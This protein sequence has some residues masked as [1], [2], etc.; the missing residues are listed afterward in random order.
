MAYSFCKKMKRHY[1]L[2]LILWASGFWFSLKAADELDPNNYR[3]IH[4]SYFDGKKYASGVSHEVF[5]KMTKWNFESK[6]AP[7]VSPQMAYKLAKERLDKI[8]MRKGLGW[9]LE[10]VGLT[11]VGSQEEGKWIWKVSFELV[12]TDGENMM[13][14]PVRMAFFV[15]MDGDLIE[16]VVSEHKR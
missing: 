2:F 10:Q 6:K 11:P 5:E 9:D 13:G 14:A 4:W 8:K 16:P 1:A 7:P 3:S 15:T 12:A